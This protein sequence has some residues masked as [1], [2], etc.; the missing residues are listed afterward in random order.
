GIEV[1]RRWRAAG[2]AFPVLIL[3][4]RGRWQDKVEGLE[5]GGDDYLVKPFHMEELLARLRALVRRAAGWSS[6]VL[7]CPPVELDPAAQQVTVDGSEVELTAFE[8]KL[9]HYL[10]LHAGEVVS[11]GELNDH[12]YE[13]DLDR[14]SN[15]LEVLLGRLRRKLD[16]ERT[17]EP[18]ETLRG[19]GYRLRLPRA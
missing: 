11:K 19:R 15:V 14:D 16:P 6:G 17:L 1:V 9:L 7:R 10:M 8:Y 4:A 12:L 13:E 18:I 5:A 2:R 3:T